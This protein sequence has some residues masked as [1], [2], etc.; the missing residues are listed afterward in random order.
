M[1]STLARSPFALWLVALGLLVTSVPVRAQSA[2]AL[3]PA[4]GTPAPRPAVAR[5]LD[6]VSR[7]A[8]AP[9][10]ATISR[11]NGAVTFLSARRDAPVPVSAA[12]G[13]EDRAR[14]FL[15]EHGALFGLA[16]GARDLLLERVTGAD[17]LGME[18]VRFRQTWKGVPVAGGEIS[19]HLVDGGVAAVA[20]RTVTGLEG[21]GVVPALP[22][23]AARRA[24][25]E[26]LARGIDLT[27]VTLSEPRLEIFDRGHLGGPRF[28]PRLAWFVEARRI[29]L[30]EYL[31]VD[32]RTGAVLLRFSQLT[33]AKN[34]EIH[35]A[36][37]PGDGVFNDLIG[38]IVRTEGG[39]VTGDSDADTAYDYAGDTYDYYSTEH[40]RD[41]FDD[42]GGKLI[43]TVHFCP[44]AA[45][46]PYGNAFWNGAQMVYG[47]GF[48]VGD[49]VDAHELTHAVTERTAELFYYMQSGALNESFSD[50]F[51]ETVDLT[52]GAGTDTPAVR[53]LLG[54]DLAGGAIRDMEDPTVYGDPGK[55][56]DPEFDCTDPGGDGGGVH[57]NSGVPNHAYELMVDGGNYNGHSVTGIGLTRAGDIEYRALTVYLLSSSGFQDDVDALLQSCYDLVGVDGITTGDCT[58]VRD[59]LDAVAMGSP[60]PCTGAASPAPDLCDPWDDPSYLFFDDFE[61]FPG[62][63]DGDPAYLTNWS[64]HILT[65]VNGVAGQGHWN[66]CCLGPYATSGHGNLFGYDWQYKGDSAVEMVSNVSI[67]AGGAFLH[68]DH[69][70]G[71]EN[72]GSIH[73]DGG[74]IEYSTNNGASWS[75]AGGLID[76]GRDYDAVLTTTSDNP[77]EGRSA[78]CGDSYGYTGTR[79]DLSSL[80]SQSV[81][82][83]FRI[84]TDFIASDYGWYIDDFGI[85]TCEPACTVADLVLSSGTVTGKTKEAACN[86]IE[87]GT[88]YGVAG[89]GDLTL[90]APHV[91]FTDGFSVASGGKL[92][93][94]IH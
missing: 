89:G 92:A 66:V 13:A 61:E 6:E 65:S 50:V 82:F 67:P 91:R 15:A 86:S 51:G 52:N 3:P 1:D 32:A 40:G 5:A 30:R 20:A 59:A 93:V 68:F 56:G 79:L 75:D 26:S 28:P 10:K 58:S 29:D 36:D 77:I 31:W 73:Y 48:P 2:P 49:D 41:S 87:A 9:V 45:H 12:G 22:A 69:A 88:S 19:V 60:W 72:Y 18:H 17:G 62:D 47:E 53:W 33:T 14:S 8:G 24:A 16:G 83:R 57:T 27:G 42:A 46:C 38:T 43:S 76:S 34:R 63:G 74:V 25:L 84:G 85:Y 35:D 78:F 39:G 94:V 54:E 37:D 11:R 4:P 70:Y 44:D 7:L 21:V 71:F 23:A 64:Q 90:V 81:R 80:A 55:I